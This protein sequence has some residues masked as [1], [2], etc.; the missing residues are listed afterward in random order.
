[1]SGWPGLRVEVLVFQFE[2]LCFL[3]SIR[4]EA[5]LFQGCVLSSPA[6]LSSGASVV[7]TDAESFRADKSL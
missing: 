7:L 2:A 3:L 1:M 6:F 5:V 4:S